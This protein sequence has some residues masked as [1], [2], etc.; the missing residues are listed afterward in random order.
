MRLGPAALNP[1]TLHPFEIAGQAAALDLV[2]DGRA[3]VGIVQGAWLDEL[4]LAEEKPL[5]ALRE[6]VEVIRRV[7]SGDRSGF[8]GTRFTIAPV[9][10][11]STRPGGRGSR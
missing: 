2:S 1:Y 7:I 4:G 10:A 11:S 8:A 9:A 6:A 5:T 3:Y